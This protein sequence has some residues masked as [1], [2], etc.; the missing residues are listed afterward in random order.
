MSPLIFA[1]KTNEQL[2]I[3]VVL[4]QPAIAKCKPGTELRTLGNMGHSHSSALG[5]NRAIKLTPQSS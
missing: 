4:N 5:T 1:S 3:E 2:E